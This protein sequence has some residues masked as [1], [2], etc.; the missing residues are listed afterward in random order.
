[1][2]Q[3]TSSP[4]IQVSIGENYVWSI[5]EVFVGVSATKGIQGPVELRIQAIVK[6]AIL[7]EGVSNP[8][9]WREHIGDAIGLNGHDHLVAY[10]VAPAIVVQIRGNCWGT[11]ANIS[12]SSSASWILP[13]IQNNLHAS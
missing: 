9:V 13:H 6:L 4:G 10:L 11:I 7:H 12:A 8:G 1:M 2:E 5:L 3:T